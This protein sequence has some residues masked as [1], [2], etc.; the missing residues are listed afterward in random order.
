MSRSFILLL[1]ISSIGNLTFAQNGVYE[2][3]VSRQYINSLS[4]ISQELSKTIFNQVKDFPNKTQLSLAFIEDETV[5]FYGIEIENDT[6]KVVNNK[7]NIFEIGSITKVFTSTILADLVVKKKINLDDNINKYFDF[8]FRDN[9]NISFINL[10]NHTSGL[11]RLPSNLDLTKIDQ[12]NPFKEYDKEKLNCYLKT[13]LGLENK[14]GKKYSYSNLGVGLL[15]YTLGRSQNCDYI[16]LLNKN[17]F[18]K[19]Q[20]TNSFTNRHNAKGRLI[21]G[22]DGVGNE[23]ENW[24]FDILFPAGGILSNVED[25]S[26]FVIAQF[27][28]SNKD[29]ALTREPT[30]TVNE[31]L[32][33]ALG[34]HII[35]L[36]SEN[37]IYWH[38]GG[39]GGY[40]SSMAV[41]LENKNGIVILS[42]VSA[43]NPNMN[44]ID[45]LCFE[46]VK[47]LEK[48]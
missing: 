47:R 41:D 6:V 43:F 10:A 15:G 7:D 1:I 35:K 36:E 28:P 34:W 23:V 31:N 42:N 2:K 16:E 3:N 8:S 40:S 9:T 33:V 27:N 4:E 29:L 5:S 38:N 24:D 30:F 12:R 14:S 21:K 48:K 13:E 11:E 17:I 19:Y 20:M 46:L 25:L 37:E 39:T 44:H 22:L 45:S 32:K 26:K 18:D